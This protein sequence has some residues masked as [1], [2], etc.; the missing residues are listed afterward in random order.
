MNLSQHIPRYVISN[1]CSLL[2]PAC[3]HPRISPP[4]TRSYSLAVGVLVFHIINFPSDLTKCQ[5]SSSVSVDE[6]QVWMCD[7]QPDL[8]LL[9][10]AASP[11]AL[12]LDGSHAHVLQRPLRPRGPDG[13]DS[14]VGSKDTLKK[15]PTATMA[16]V[17]PGSPRLV[18]G[19]PS[20]QS[21]NLGQ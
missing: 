19:S 8:P 15:I 12:G 3:S 14:S 5:V 20:R 18:L 16:A 4:C 21:Q 2:F 6:G 17:I 10:F 1:N 7:G 9:W 13:E 11:P